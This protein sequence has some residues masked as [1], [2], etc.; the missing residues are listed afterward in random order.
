MRHSTNH[1]LIAC[2]WDKS[3]P[4][5]AWNSIAV[6][7]NRHALRGDYYLVSLNVSLKRLAGQKL[8]KT[9][10]SPIV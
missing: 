9:K 6:M 1:D 2:P 4:Q 10:H 5:F 3:A 8:S 7:P